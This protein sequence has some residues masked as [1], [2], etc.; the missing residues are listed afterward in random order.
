MIGFNSLRPWPDDIYE[1]N[2]NKA[3]GGVVEYLAEIL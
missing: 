1:V 2:T 3:R